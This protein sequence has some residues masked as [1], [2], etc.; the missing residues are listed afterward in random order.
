MKRIRG[1]H[2]CSQ[3]N[4]ELARNTISQAVVGFNVGA[5]PSLEYAVSDET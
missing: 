5:K 4:A 2:S 1:S 3:L